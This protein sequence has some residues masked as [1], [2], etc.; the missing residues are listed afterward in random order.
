M[1]FT[2]DSLEQS[3]HRYSDERNGL[4]QEII[5]DFA[6][7]FPNL[8]FEIQA[9]SR[10]INA[11]AI[12]RAKTRIVRL[13]GGLAFHPLIGSDALAFTLLHEVGHHLSSGG[14]LA[15]CKNMGCECAADRWAVTKGMTRL[16]KGTGRALQMEKAIEGL[17]AL[18]ARTLN[19]EPAQTNK[20][21][22]EDGLT[23]CWALAWPKRKLHLTGL[24]P[25]P[26]IRRCY[27]SDFYVSWSTSH[28]GEKN[29]F[30]D[31]SRQRSR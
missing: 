19:R 1:L 8:K 22:S 27:L 18:N 25:M 24:T 16:K 9:Q 26:I 17:D 28:S 30:F 13:Y 10:T 6:E 12:F 29:G 11:Q 5:L 31:A 15:F 14:R 3:D 7:A 2:T 20:S 4:L 23:M 21:N